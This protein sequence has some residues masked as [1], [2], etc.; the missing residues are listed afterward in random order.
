MLWYSGMV[1]QTID[2]VREE[3]DVWLAREPAG[4]L[5]II[6]KSDAIEID[7]VRI[8]RSSN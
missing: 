6:Y 2:L 4:Y 7:D 1:G 3:A 8:V 5:N